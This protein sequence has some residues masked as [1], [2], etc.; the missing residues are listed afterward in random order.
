MVVEGEATPRVELVDAA[1]S[2]GAVQAL[3]SG[4]ISLD[5]GEVRGLVGENGAGKSTS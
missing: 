2:Y 3:R 1:K 4:S 5:A